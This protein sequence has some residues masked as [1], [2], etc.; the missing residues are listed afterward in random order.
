M[1][2]EREEAETGTPVLFEGGGGEEGREWEA[3]E[4]DGEESP[5]PEC[6]G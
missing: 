6:G 2:E 4:D 1:D 5:V 3:E